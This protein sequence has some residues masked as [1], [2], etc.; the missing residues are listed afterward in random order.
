MN[1][2][3]LITILLSIRSN[4]L[5][6]GPAILSQ[7]SLWGFKDNNPTADVI[8]GEQLIYI[9]GSLDDPSKIKEN[10]TN[11]VNIVYRCTGMC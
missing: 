4:H 2:P 6:P 9:Y 10:D 11:T 3:L 8:S 5:S 7:Y 1:F